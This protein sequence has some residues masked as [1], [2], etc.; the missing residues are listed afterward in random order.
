MASWQVTY[1]PGTKPAVTSQLNAATISQISGFD[2]GVPL[3]EADTTLAADFTAVITAAKGL[4]AAL[5]GPAQKRF[6]DGASLPGSEASRMSLSVPTCRDRR[7]PLGHSTETVRSVFQV[8]S[9]WSPT[10]T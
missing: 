2:P 9:T 7:P 1:G 3:N 8:M 4:V 10:L 5:T 6:S